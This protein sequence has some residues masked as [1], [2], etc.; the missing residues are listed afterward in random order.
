MCDIE[1]RA[2]TTWPRWYPCERVGKHE[3]EVSI[4]AWNG[5]ETDKTT[6]HVCGQHKRILESGKSMNVKRGGKSIGV[7]G[8][9]SEL[10]KAKIEVERRKDLLDSHSSTVKHRERMVGQEACYMAPWLI[11]ELEGE[12]RFTDLV[13]N[14]KAWL[15]V[16]DTHRS[17]TIDLEDAEKEYERLRA[18]G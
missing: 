16:K 11:E 4:L 5:T 2:D 8:E 18:K 3:V 1:V 17:M 12:D 9:K 14:L 10:G 6:I 13:E 15:S 7:R